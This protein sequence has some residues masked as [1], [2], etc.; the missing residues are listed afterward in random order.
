MKRKI[1]IIAAILLSSASLKSQDVVKHTTLFQPLKSIVHYWKD[2]VSIAYIHEGNDGGAFIYEAKGT[3]LLSAKI[4]TSCEITDFK[5]LHDTVFF[6]GFTSLMGYDQGFVGFFD[7]ENLFFFGGTAS[8]GVIPNTI[9]NTIAG[10]MSAPRRM[11][12]YVSGGIVHYALVGDMSPI[13]HPNHPD[14]ATLED[15]Y[16]DGIQW[17]FVNLM[18]K[19]ESEY[20]TDIAATGRY[21]VATGHDR[22]NGHCIIRAFRSSGTYLNNPVLSGKLMDIADS[23]AT[24]DCFIEPLDYDI[25]AIT[26]HYR[27]QSEAGMSVKTLRISNASPYYTPANSISIQ[28]SGTIAAP[29]PWSIKETRCNSDLGRLFVLQDMDQPVHSNVTSTVLELVLTAS[30]LDILGTYAYWYNYK[31]LHDIDKYKSNGFI[32]TGTNPAGNLLFLKK[33]I[34][35]GLSS[36]IESEKIPFISAPYTS[37]LRDVYENTNHNTYHNTITTVTIEN[38]DTAIDCFTEH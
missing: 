15:A 37:S 16:F 31:T 25:F 13:D 9:P 4:K 33:N 2:S 23:S 34:T 20:Y 21:V 24:G 3:N 36:C 30:K 8:Y 38:F 28:Q 32:A 5:I 27:T 35:Y 19:H 26:H 6:C 1:I 17:H 22:Y 7:I 10:R 14:G 11:D 12:L 18:N 29:L